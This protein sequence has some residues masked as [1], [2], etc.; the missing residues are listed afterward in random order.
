MAGNSVAKIGVGAP[1]ATGGVLVTAAGTTLPTGVSGS[2]SSFT[3][4][5]YVAD[6]GLRPSGE[7]SSSPIYDWAGDLIYSP[8]DKHSAQFQFK[9][10]ATFD[11]DVL[12]EV[13][14]DENVSTVGSLTTVL[15]TGSPLAIHPWVFDMKDGD[16][17]TRIAVPLGQITGVK[18]DPFV[19]N[20]LQAFDVTLECYKDSSGRKAYRY[21]DDGSAAS[22][23][24]IS[25]DLPATVGAA[26]GDLVTLAGTNFTGTTGVT[27]DGDAAAEFIVVNDQ[28]LVFT[29]PAQSAGT[30]AVIVTNATGPSASYTGVTYV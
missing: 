21:Y 9:L 19:R 15:E 5:G 8:Q 13:F 18:E 3:K 16:K 14:G 26:G 1:L 20:A 30:Y 11:S 22:V 4:L 29:A 17:R 10:Y 2:T 25:S 7:R 12:A 23:P 27:V 28:T 6:D 24:T